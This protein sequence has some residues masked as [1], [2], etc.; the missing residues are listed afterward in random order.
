MA[1]TIKSLVTFTAVPPGGQVS[2]PH[3]LKVGTRAVRPDI[4]ERS[5][6]RFSVVLALTD[7]NQV[8]V[9]NDSLVVADCLVLC[10]YWHTIERAFGAAQV[11]QLS[12][13]T[14]SP[15]NDVA[16]LVG[17]DSLQTSYNG[18]SG[19]ALSTLRQGIQIVDAPAVLVQPMLRLNHIGANTQDMILLTRAF[20]S[21][22][23]NGIRIENESAG[24]IGILIEQR[25]TTGLLIQ[26]DAGSS[27]SGT[28]ISVAYNT[29]GSTGVLLSL[30]KAPAA[31]TS[32]SLVS[33]T[34]GNFATGILI[35]MVSTG[36]NDGINLALTPTVVTA[37]R[38][39]RVALLGGVNNI[40]SAIEVT[41]GGAGPG[42]GIFLTSAGGQHGIQITHTG[43]ASGIVITHSGVGGV[44]NGLSVTVSP[45]AAATTGGVGISVGVNSTGIPLNVS[46]SGGAIATVQIATNATAT[47]SSIRVVHGTATST[48]VSIQNDVGTG[49]LLALSRTPAALTAGTGLNISFSSLTSGIL[50]NLANTGTGTLLALTKTPAAPTAGTVI[51]ITTNVN[52]TGAVILVAHAGTAAFLDVSN[53]GTGRY[54]T[55]SHTST[56]E[57]WR[58]TGAAGAI[59][60]VM[61]VD[62][63]LG[64]DVVPPTP[65]SGSLPLTAMKRAGAGFTGSESQEFHGTGSTVGAV[66]ADIATILLADNTAYV[67]RADVVGRASGGTEWAAYSIAR[68]FR[69]Q[70]AGVATVIGALATMLTNEANVLA[71]ASLEVTANSVVVRVTGTL[72]Q[73]YAWATRV[74]VTPVATS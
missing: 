7:T 21:G 61:T 52:A 9:Q 4:A 58:M 59:L 55:L 51:S 38:G 5:S 66:T 40:G 19:I 33:I 31:N 54:L 36:T 28:A 69:R 62:G 73:T 45:A 65:A 22:V 26:E 10:E 56:A 41:A 74:T 34:A 42:S 60:S 50:V 72:G 15:D 24:S 70:A 64:I 57:I 14:F 35:S 39:I 47:G 13:Q 12:P 37:Q 2:L 67:I 27:A 18:G 53:T 30:A 6:A 49:T 3:N 23:G 11:V 16:V 48:A 17:A 29:T 25:A 32:G 8:T 43:T 20:G 63:R 1:T 46:G 44:S 68:G 71:D